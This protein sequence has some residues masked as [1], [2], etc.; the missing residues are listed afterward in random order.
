MKRNEVSAIIGYWRNGMTYTEISLIMDI[1]E[2][3][4]ER[5]VFNYLKGIKNIS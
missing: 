1:S 4:A 2:F 3:D 5:V